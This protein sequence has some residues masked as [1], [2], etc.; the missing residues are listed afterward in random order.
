MHDLAQTL[1]DCN[2]TSVEFL[3]IE[4]D[5]GLTFAEI[6]RQSSGDAEKSARNRTY[7]RTA[8]E[9][10]LRY[11]GRVVMTEAESKSL[12]IKVARLKLGLQ[13]LGESS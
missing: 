10:I 2:A 4:A 13:T 5:T 1:R 3:N 11:I 12:A 6:A 9:T 7:A 8:Y